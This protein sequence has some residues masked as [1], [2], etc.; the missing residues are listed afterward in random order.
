MTKEMGAYTETFDNGLRLIFMPSPTHVVYCGYT[1]GAGTR[2]ELPNE[3]GMAHFL[4][5]MSFK[6]TEKRRSWHILN[7]MES[8]GGDLNAFT[9]KEETVFYCACL[10]RDFERAVELLTD[11][12][13]HSTFPAAGIEK[14]LGVIL[15][16]I[17]SYEDTPSDLIFDEFEGLL[18]KGDPL[19][20]NILGLPEQLK[21][22]TGADASSFVS[23][24]YNP[25]NMVF[26]IYGDLDWKKVRK[27]ASR[28]CGSEKP[29]YDFVCQRKPLPEYLP[30]RVETHRDTHQAH[31][32]IGSRGLAG[33]DPDRMALY[34]L[35]N[36]LGGPGM[37]SRLNI[38]LREKRGLVYNVE[39]NST[40]YTDTGVF[41]IYFGCDL[42]D[43][44]RCM[45]LSFRELERL[46]SQNLTQSQLRAAKKQL[47]GQM[48]VAGDNFENVALGMGKA[49]LHYGS[50]QTRSELFER[51]EAV[52]SQQ[53]REV[54]CRVLN[55]D[56]QTV[57]I[58]K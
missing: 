43:V 49:F 35:N 8:V 22:F 39:S 42:E 28:Y 10:D 32:M 45:E 21:G 53:M 4:E 52:T 57:L 36:I 41:C 51:I 7:R 17:Q 33:A 55:P 14:E 40:S 13:F 37:N 54:A 9:T 15:D 50:Y 2:D 47:M 38:S 30:C 11:L 24:H 29:H 26:F 31:V 16:E 6:G 18:F 19:G 3:Q 12:V 48:G 25:G 20:N 58:Y 44:D 34:L 56:R 46:C 27:V 5:H 23:R 1:V